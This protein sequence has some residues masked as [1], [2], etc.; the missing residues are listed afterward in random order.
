MKI[1]IR[2]YKNLNSTVSLSFVIRFGI[3]LT[4][5]GHGSFAFE[6]KKE[7]IPFLTTVGFEDS[8]ALKV[9]PYIGVMDFLI[10][11]SMLILPLRIFVI[12]AFVWAFS[13][14]LIRPIS[15][16]NIME[17]VERGSNWILPIVLLYIDKHK[18]TFSNLLK[19]VE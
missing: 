4:F 2:A 12:W 16:M 6:G 17:F 10:A 1:I 14:A 13:T 18:L 3:F 11:I 19:T 15:G 5:I 9:M 8:T 7:W